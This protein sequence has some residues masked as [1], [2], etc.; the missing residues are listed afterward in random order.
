M[1][2]DGSSVSSDIAAGDYA[3]PEFRAL[4][5]PQ[6]TQLQDTDALVS[7]QICEQIS[8][9]LKG[10]MHITNDDYSATTKDLL[11]RAWSMAAQLQHYRVE[12]QHII[13][14]MVTGRYSSG[15]PSEFVGLDSATLRTL[16]IRTMTALARLETAAEMSLVP[17]LWATADL[18]SWIS[19]ALRIAQSRGEPLE[20]DDLFQVMLDAQQ[21]GHL[22]HDALQ[23][24]F[25]SLGSAE[26]PVIGGS[27]GP[28]SVA[29]AL[30]P[31]E[32]GESAQ[33]SADV[34]TREY[35]NRTSAGITEANRAIRPAQ[36]AASLSRTE[37]KR[38]STAIDTI[39]AGSNT[40]AENLAQLRT[41]LNE[42][43]SQLTDRDTQ[44]VA[45]DK[46]VA[47]CRNHLSE[48]GRHTAAIGDRLPR[49]PAGPWVALAV[50]GV[51]AIGL[52]LG[53]VLSYPSFLEPVVG[54]GRTTVAN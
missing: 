10:A 36:Q 22:L 45:L 19:E 49:P 34:G 4:A 27:S 38:L 43:R 24:S 9:R 20:P 46:S 14:G 17:N 48:L 42:L 37:I 12:P 26:L 3:P 33:S 35:R 50:V 39:P 25:G 47:H 51:V 7:D 53:V 28:P 21:S 18:V 31:I 23:D 44:L 32:S 16:R 15:A 30:I 5:E 1:T 8:D 41:Q 52:V 54:L 11:R 40:V 2:Q 13:V 6:K 29:N